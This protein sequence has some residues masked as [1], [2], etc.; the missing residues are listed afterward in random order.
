MYKITYFRT[1]YEV[2]SYRSRRQREKI[3]EHTKKLNP[4]PLTPPV[5]QSTFTEKIF[6]VV[7]PV[8]NAYHFGTV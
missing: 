2:E 8:P 5:G 3:H 6:G 1:F 4:S 7:E